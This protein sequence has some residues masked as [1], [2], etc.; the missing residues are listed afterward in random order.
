MYTEGSFMHLSRCARSAQKI[1]HASNSKNKQQVWQRSACVNMFK[2]ALVIYPP[3]VLSFAGCAVNNQF[4]NFHFLFSLWRHRINTDTDKGSEQQRAELRE[5]NEEV[6]QVH[7]TGNM[8][9]KKREKRWDD[10]KVRRERERERER[11]ELL[12]KAS[13][14]DG[15]LD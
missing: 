2:V 12:A 6:E 1:S 4:S 15:T 8:R 14:N 9:E 5:R 13:F 11:R 3:R 7:R 10:E